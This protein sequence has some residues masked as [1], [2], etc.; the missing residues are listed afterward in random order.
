MKTALLLVMGEL[1]RFVMDMNEVIGGP[2]IGIENC[3][4]CKKEI[5][6]HRGGSWDWG[7]KRCDACRGRYR[8]AHGR[9]LSPEEAAQVR[10]DLGIK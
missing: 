4:T 3:V 2:S 7:A 9:R 10:K 1:R 6:V 5:E 8:K